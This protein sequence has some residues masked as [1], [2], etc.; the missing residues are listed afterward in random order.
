MFLLLLFFFYFKKLYLELF[1][2]NDA[3][4][5]QQLKIENEIFDRIEGDFVVKAHYSLIHDNYLI[6]LEEYMQG[7]DFGS[8][9]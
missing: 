2:Q 6:F 5:L 8:L 9:L 3:F 4:N 1:Q 7:G